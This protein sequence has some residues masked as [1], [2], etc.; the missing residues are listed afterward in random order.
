MGERERTVLKDWTTRK[1][2]TKTTARTVERLR[3]EGCDKGCGVENCL[4]GLGGAACFE[5]MCCL[6]KVLLDGRR[7][8]EAK[9]SRGDV[10]GCRSEDER[11][12]EDDE[13]R[14]E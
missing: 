14:E 5:S 4:G 3:L 12:G 10:S 8:A 9:G 13:R 2:R 6:E 7:V 11:E 1:K